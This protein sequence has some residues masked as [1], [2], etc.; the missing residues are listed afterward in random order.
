[1]SAPVARALDWDALMRAGMH[2]LRLLPEQFW[3]L[4]PGE[5]LVMLGAERRPEPMTRDRLAELAAQYPDQPSIAGRAGK[6]G[7][8]NYDQQ[9]RFSNQPGQH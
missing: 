9:E 2:G 8:E 3:S 6:Q 7:A 1:M 5:L 4:T